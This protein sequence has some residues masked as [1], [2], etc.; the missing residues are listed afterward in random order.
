MGCLIIGPRKLG[1]GHRPGV[2]NGVGDMDRDEALRLL[3][4]GPNGIA[5][6]NRRRKAKEQIPDLREANLIKAN[7]SGADLGGAY[8]IK[9]N[10][11]GASLS[12][13]NLSGANL[14]EANLSGSNLSG[15]N[16]SG[17][18][19][20][21]AD[22]GGA[23][24]IEANLS[25]ANLSG[26]DLSGGYLIEANLSGADLG[27]VD[28]I[29]AN[30]S[31]ANLSGADLRGANLKRAN[32][33]GADFRG[34]RCWGTQFADIDLSEAVG[35]ELVQHQ[36]PSTVGIDTLF[37]SKG[38]IPEVFLRGCGV[39]ESVIVNRFALIGAMEPIQF[40]SCFISY[41]TQDV[42]FATRL[43]SKMREKGLRVWF[44]PEDIE[45]GKKIHEQIDRA[46][47]VHDRLLLVLSEH[48][49]SSNWVR[50]EIRRARRAELKENRRK[51]FPIRLVEFKTL[52]DWECFDADVG[53]DSAVEIREYFIPDFSNWKDHDSF[54]AAFARLLNDLKAEA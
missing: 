30:L 50:D 54:E 16:L 35:L 53:K 14:R 33:K 11:S 23:Y 48:S 24:L 38:N 28:L 7:L 9:A 13:A 21:G 2:I 36:G 19:L 18:N 52:E 29:E 46:I 31:G 51:L 22:L 5:E 15:S 44:A 37:R 25:G 41:S 39:P 17:A 43:H 47:Q 6:W 49:M 45:S 32:L 42:E 12:G 20:S 1:S 10:L 27:G 3:G 8:L 40:Y 4:S 34:A 26:A